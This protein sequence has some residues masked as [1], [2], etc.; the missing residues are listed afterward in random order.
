ML[1]IAFLCSRELANQLDGAE[2]LRHCIPNLLKI[3]LPP[4]TELDIDFIRLHKTSYKGVVKAHNTY[5]R[6]YG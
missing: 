5:P 1:S 6:R 2:S 3:K 4:V